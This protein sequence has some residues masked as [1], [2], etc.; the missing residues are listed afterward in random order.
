MSDDLPLTGIKVVELCNVAAGPFC[1]ML[2]ADMGADLIKVENP[3][4]GDTL[5]SWPP[6]SD[7]YSENFAS[8]NRNKRSV[9]LNLKLATDVDLFKALI[10]DADV[11]LENN[12]PGVMNRLG[13]G[14]EA[15]SNINPKLIY[16]SISAYG[17]VGPRANEGGFD[18]TIQAMSGIMS[19]TGEEGGAP[20]KCGVPVSDFTAGLYGAFSITS[21]LR[22]VA[23]TG[24]GTHLDI[25]MLG[26]T[27][28]IAALQ[29][30]EYFGSGRDPVKLGSAH[31]R[32]APYRVFKAKDDYFGMAA[33]N[34]VLWHSVC[35]TVN[36]IDL[37]DDERFSSPTNRAQHQDDLL[38]IL[39]SEFALDTA[40]VWLE[41]FREAGVPCAPINAYSQVL[42]DPQVKYMN[43]IHPIDLPNGVQTQT[44]GSP[45]RIGS[46]TLE[47]QR[48]PPA[49]G[50]H[51]DEVLGA[52]MEK[53]K[54]HEPFSFS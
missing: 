29:T 18:L 5:R 9:T 16:C 20:V 32:N 47:I 50:E 34:N 46:K 30:S 51:N 26:S 38:I 44:F 48:R 21:T 12:R 43:W 45:I 31:P 14:Y 25:S 42:A 4:G 11:L 28:G 24:V 19:V 2:L 22:L 1:G 36:R 15:L 37:L 23:Q 13:L 53:A 39:E 8:L 7:G 49:L 52:L 41:R 33:G 3:E 10:K 27:L 6:F 40:E 35:K 54:Q 17:Q